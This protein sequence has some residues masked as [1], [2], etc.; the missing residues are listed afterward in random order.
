MACTYPQA[1]ILPSTYGYVIDGKYMSIIMVG[2]S[3]GNVLF[4]MCV[5]QL[6]GAL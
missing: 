5:A 6:F 3:I 2:G 1:K 4:V